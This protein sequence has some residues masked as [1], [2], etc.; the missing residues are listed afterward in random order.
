VLGA[1]FDYPPLL[2]PGRHC[3]SLP[4]IEALCVTPFAG[5]AADRR[6]SLFAAFEQFVGRL[7]NARIRCDLFIDGSFFTEK[8]DPGD[9][10]VIVI[11]DI[12]VYE[13]LSNPQRD[14]LDAVNGQ[15]VSGVDSFAVASYPREH[16][17]FGTAL[18]CGNAGDAYGLE[19]S[20]IW[21]KGYACI[22]LCETDVGNRICS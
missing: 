19:H 5:A 13:A 9:V 3:L 10:D 17:Y 15:F 2:A 18:D 1:K 12:S 22:R 6:R 4:E 16:P 14:V 20:Q 8:P 21:L 11:T 7:R